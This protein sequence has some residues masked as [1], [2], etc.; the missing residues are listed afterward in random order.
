MDE[1]Q[2]LTSPKF[3]KFEVFKTE[4]EAKDFIKKWD[5]SKGQLS[6]IGHSDKGYYITLPN[7][8]SEGINNAIKKTEQILKINVSLGFE[9]V[10]G[11]H[12]GQCH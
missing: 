3:Y 12:W 6:T 2:L 4:D 5:N 8:V 1:N 11:K 10:T 7:V 9:W